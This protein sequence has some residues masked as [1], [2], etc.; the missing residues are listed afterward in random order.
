[1]KSFKNFLTEARTQASLEA[2]K[3]GLTHVGAGHYADD[4]GNVVAKSEGGVKLVDYE[5]QQAQQQAQP[6]A[7]PD[8]AAAP[9][10]EPA[11]APAPGESTPSAAPMVNQGNK[12]ITFTFGRFQG[13]HKGHEKLINK[14][15]GI[16]GDGEYR[17]YPSHSQDNKKNPYDIDSKVSLMQQL[18]PDH[19]DA[20]QNDS[21]NGRNIF[22]IL[23][24]LHAQ[25]YS[26]VNL[27]VGAD[28]LKQFQDMVNKY[29]GKL[30]NF[31][32]I[33]L[34]SAGERSD[35]SE[36][37]EGLSASKMRK[38]AAEGDFKKFKSG[39][40][41]HVEDED[42]QS[43]FDDLRKRMGIKEGFEYWDICP[44][45]YPQELREEYIQGNVYKL[46]EK[47]CNMN[48]GI[49]GRIISRGPTYVIILDENNDIHRTWIK[50]L[51]YSKEPLEVGT[52][53]YREY[54]QRLTP[55]EKIRSFGR[56]TKRNK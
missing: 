34:H 43:I 30:Y 26:D 50:D 41:G 3:K 35:D 12:P 23:K 29:N 22:D 55:F 39:L 9:A 27:V 20:I 4:T 6:A 28:R 25:G 47:V 1:M 53:T 49:H 2:K 18:F 19:A 32:S 48:S 54:L 13:V 24:N 36:D 42:A 40:P 17:I 45:L 37:V 56:S 38:A 21:E 11:A 46:N 44:R 14:V 33:N 5:P 8:P 16:A 7:A 10:P 31:N 51:S 52:D 15:A